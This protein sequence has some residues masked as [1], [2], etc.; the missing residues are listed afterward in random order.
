[1]SSLLHSK[2]ENKQ[3]VVLQQSVVTI[4]HLLSEILR[5]D[6]KL[7]ANLKDSSLKTTEQCVMLV[8]RGTCC[9][10]LNVKLKSLHVLDLQVLVRSD[11]KVL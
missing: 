8:A 5:N 4:Y 7:S 11:E 6:P 1:M 9:L 3:K 10:N 2:S